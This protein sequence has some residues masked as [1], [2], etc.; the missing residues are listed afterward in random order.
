M[1]EKCRLLFRMC[2]LTPHVVH[3][4]LMKECLWVSAFFQC[5]VSMTT[6][7]QWSTKMLPRQRSWCLS[8]L[9]W[10]SMGRSSEM[11]S[12][13]TWTVRWKKQK[14]CC[15]LEVFQKSPD[16]QDSFVLNTFKHRSVTLSA[17]ASPEKLMTPEMF[18]EILCDDL[19]LNPLAFVPAIA[20]AIRQQIESYPTDSILDEQTDQRVIIKVCL[21][22]VLLT[23]FGRSTFR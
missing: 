18:A 23:K 3:M 6:T 10:K 11:P 5:I 14:I 13:G 2:S 12:P 9:T 20:S 21:N 17:F 15:S 1:K 4:V 22:S 16:I 19:D 8:A 7:L